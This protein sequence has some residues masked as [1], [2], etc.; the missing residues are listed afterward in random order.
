MSRVEH[1]GGQ[2]LIGGL[3]RV[4]H[5]N[6]YNAHLQ[7]SVLM[8]EGIPEHEPQRLLKDAATPLVSLLKQRGYKQSDLLTE[9]SFCGFGKLRQIDET[10]WETPSSHY[11]ESIYAHGKPKKTCFF[12]TGYVQ[13]VSEHESEETACQCLD[14]SADRYEVSDAA[15]PMDNYLQH[16]FPLRE[17]V[18]ER[19]GFEECADFNTPVEEGQ[20][21]EAVA[22]LPLFGKF[23][24]HDTGLIDAFGVV[25]TN[26]FADYYNRISYETFFAMKNAGIP[27]D[28]VK[29]TF[30]QSGHVCAFNTFGG[31]MSSPEW[32][33]V[34]EPSCKTRE[35]WFH[36]M[37]AV[38]NALGWGTY[39]IER[40]TAE[41]ELVV[42]I[43]N[44]YEGVGYRHIYPQSDDKQL[45]FLAMGATLGLV[46]LLWKVDIRQKP[47]LTQDFFVT[48]FNNPENSYSV[49]QTHA[50]AAGD[51]YDRIVVWKAE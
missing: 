26:H 50:I 46:H 33:A 43:Y 22:G 14:A 36:G 37:V 11:G 23:G 40:L 2:T 31:I 3:N 19:F 13:G 16:D 47:T 20:V 29:D 25:L 48:Q 39:R 24:P 10:A 30:I 4:Y 9:F 17:D 38:I 28:D 45:S 18:P 1:K 7:M 34:V 51:D 15:A 32:Y 5:C 21:I 6:H 35:D 44:S 8:S 42:R 27:V 12:N 41:K 49:E